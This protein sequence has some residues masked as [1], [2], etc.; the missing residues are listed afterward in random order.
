MEKREPW[1]HSLCKRQH[2][3]QLDVPL[4]HKWGRK[5]RILFATVFH[6]IGQCTIINNS[7][8]EFQKHFAM[9]TYHTYTS[10]WSGTRLITVALSKHQAIY[11]IDRHDHTH[12]DLWQLQSC[13]LLE[14]NWCCARS[15]EHD[16]TGAAA[17]NIVCY[18]QPQHLRY[19]KLWSKVLPQIVTLAA[20]FLILESSLKDSVYLLADS[21]TYRAFF[22]RCHDGIGAVFANAQ[23]CT[24]DQD[25]SFVGLHAHTAFSVL[26]LCRSQC[27]DLLSNL[28]KLR[29]KLQ[30]CRSKLVT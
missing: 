19:H 5:F 22:C 10:T 27:R 2:S 25:V 24:R 11:S 16:N 3:Y 20:L 28:F 8:F 15:V 7:T 30:D 6:S 14:I 29:N 18:A 23:M 21:A 1:I 12:G 17:C 13:V 9:H 26:Y 4:W